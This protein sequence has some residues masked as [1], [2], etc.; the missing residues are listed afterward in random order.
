VLSARFFAALPR[1]ALFL[2]GSIVDGAATSVRPNSRRVAASRRRGR[3][4]SGS[5]GA[6]RRSR[7]GVASQDHVSVAAPRERP[8]PGTSAAVARS[9]V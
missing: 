4:R 5:D 9:R 2:F 3:H 1:I 8:T 7:P 6:L